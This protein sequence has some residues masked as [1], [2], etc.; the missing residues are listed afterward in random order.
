MWCDFI[1]KEIERVRIYSSL[2]LKPSVPAV[3][4]TLVLWKPYYIQRFFILTL[5][6]FVYLNVIRE[7][8]MN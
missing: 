5:A 6:S 7:N 2:F 4:R 3:L 1:G 8:A